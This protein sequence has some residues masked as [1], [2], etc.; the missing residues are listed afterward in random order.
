MSRKTK[1][2]PHTKRQFFAKRRLNNIFYT[3]DNCRFSS[4]PLTG[5][6]KVIVKLMNKETKRY[7]IEA[8][9]KFC[10]YK[11]TK[12]IL[13]LIIIEQIFR[14]KMLPDMSKLSREKRL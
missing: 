14:G 7:V 9:I 11:P 2:L 4:L 10:L 3:D 5:L 1:F 8:E 6:D 12:T 13:H